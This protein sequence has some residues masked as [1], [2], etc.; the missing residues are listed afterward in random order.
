MEAPSKPKRQY[1]RGR[2]DGLQNLKNLFRA[3]HIPECY[4]HILAD[5]GSRVSPNRPRVVSA[6]KHASR[7]PDVQ[8]IIH[9]GQSTEFFAA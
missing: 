3:P 8:R 4:K 2:S 1:F 7:S 5:G 9:S 6:G